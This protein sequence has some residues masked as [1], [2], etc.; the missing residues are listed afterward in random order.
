MAYGVPLN[1]DLP[2]IGIDTF[3]AGA[4]DVNVALQALID[5]VEQKVRPSD[6]DI[7]ADL[8]FK[9]G[10]TSFAATEL[11]KAAFAPGGNLAAGTHP[12]SMFFKLIDGELYANDNNGN[13]VKIT[14]AGSVAAPLG[15]ITGAGYGI[16]GVEVN[17]DSG[18]G[19][20]RMRL[21]AGPN[22]FADMVVKEIRMDEGSHEYRLIAPSISADQGLTFPLRP[23]VGEQLVVMSDLGVMTASDVM[24]PGTGTISI[25]GQL[26][27]TGKIKATEYLYTQLDTLMISAVAGHLRGSGTFSTTGHYSMNANDDLTFPIQLRAGERIVKYHA[28]G[29]FLGGASGFTARLFKRAYT[30]GSRVQIGVTQ[31]SGTVAST[32]YNLNE[33][34]L[35]ETVIA[36]TEYYLIVT[37]SAS[38]TALITGCRI[39]VD[40]PV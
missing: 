12:A 5:V 9:S 16:G 40:R 18:N 37:M 27:T 33:G 13:Q 2:A 30:A 23:A 25:N 28:T 14:A 11:L 32:F 15:N 3:A 22:D 26:Q 35:T 31:T 20:Y 39:E 38:S 34:G 4:V 8:S 21:G 29:Q 1:L 19:A 36:D 17:W 7:N 24:T 10:A 6:M